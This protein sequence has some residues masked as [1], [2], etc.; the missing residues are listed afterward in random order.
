MK[1]YIRKRI[2]RLS[3]YQS[4]LI[5]RYLKKYQKK[6]NEKRRKRAMQTIL[7]SVVKHKLSERLKFMCLLYDLTAKK[8]QKLNEW[9]KDVK[10]NKLRAM[11]YKWNLFLINGQNVHGGQNLH[12]KVLP[13]ELV[14]FKSK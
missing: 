11:Q 13:S 9:Y 5:M 6:F 8:L 14:E 7:S 10:A 4:Y 2:K 3:I 1:K 12:I